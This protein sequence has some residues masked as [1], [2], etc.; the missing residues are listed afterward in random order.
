MRGRKRDTLVVAQGWYVAVRWDLE[1]WVLN[2][3][4]RILH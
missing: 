3:R 4:S 2:T 1:I